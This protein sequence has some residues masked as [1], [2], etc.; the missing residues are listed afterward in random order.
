[1][2][3]N[4]RI[5]TPV[6]VNNTQRK[7]SQ[8]AESGNNIINVSENVIDEQ[9]VHVRSASDDMVL[10]GKMKS[11]EEGDEVNIGYNFHYFHENK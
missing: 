4:L 2:D 8:Q 11:K 3:T 9:K 5:L 1:M 10:H 6:P 7:T